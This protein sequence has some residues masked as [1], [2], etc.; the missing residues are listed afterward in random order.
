MLTMF[1]HFWN[2]NGADL[3][4][5]TFWVRWTLPLVDHAVLFDHGSDDGS[6]EVVKALAPGWEVRKSSCPD[7]EAQRAD[8]ELED[9]EREF[10]GW[11]VCLNTTEFAVGDLRRVCARVERDRPDAP[12]VWG[13]A[14]AVLDPDGQEPLRAYAGPA[15]H[16]PAQRRRGVVKPP[17]RSRLL[18]RLP[19]GRYTHGRHASFAVHCEPTPLWGLLWY[20]MSPW[21]ECVARKLQIQRRVPKSDLDAGRGFHHVMTEQY[22]RD[23]RAGLWPPGVDLGADPVLGPLLAETLAT[24]RA[25]A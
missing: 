21:P 4:L 7:F 1:G 19:S 13:S 5:M 23:W 10:G 20:A 16:L 9:A 18:H 25:T 17:G 6:A 8:W 11:K 14:A 15:D 24:H 12:G 22:L 3:S 2:E